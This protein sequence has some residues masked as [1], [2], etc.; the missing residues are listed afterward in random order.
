VPM[1]I[2][3]FRCQHTLWQALNQRQAPAALLLPS[4]K[5]RRR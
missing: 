1:I 3:A 4:L 5:M 2:P